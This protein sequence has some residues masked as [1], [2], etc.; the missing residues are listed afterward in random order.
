MQI[1]SKWD[2]FELLDAGNG[3]KLEKWGRYKIIRPDPQVL[4]PKLYDDNLWNS[5]H[6]DLFWE[7]H[8]ISDFTASDTFRSGRYVLPL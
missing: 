3:N 1:S 8:F 4:W 7:S 6:A 5:V 2:D